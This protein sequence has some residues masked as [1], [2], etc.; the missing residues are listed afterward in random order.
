MAYIIL[1]LDVLPPSKK[2]NNSS[3]DT[4][5]EYVLLAVTALK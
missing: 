1:N 4:E 2:K 5:G 3:L